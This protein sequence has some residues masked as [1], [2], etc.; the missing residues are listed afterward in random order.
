MHELGL[1]ERFLALPHDE[2]RQIA[3][4]SVGDARHRSPISRICPPAASS[5]RSCR[6]GTF[7][8][9]SPTEARRYPSFSLRLQAEVTDLDRGGRRVDGVRR[10]DADGP[11][12][13]RADL[14]VGADGRH[15]T[16]RERAG[17]EVDDFG[18]PIDVLWFRLPHGAEQVPRPSGYV[19]AGHILVMLDR[20]DY[21]QCGFVIAKGSFARLRAART[22]GVPRARSAR[23]R[24][25]LRERV[26][27]L[28]RL[29]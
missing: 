8:I 1:L 19:G 21:W 13:V 14:V 10:D 2:V 18:A 27:E 4:T 5:W 26:A 12:E 15:S 7:S 17:L 9:S 20:G 23:S 6:S 29:G 3:A 24:P 25:S 22:P 28:T 11:L 16:V